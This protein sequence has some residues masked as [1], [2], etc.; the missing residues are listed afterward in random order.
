MV[1]EYKDL[2]E[3]VLSVDKGIRFAGVADYHGNVLAARYR[4]DIEK[5]P[6]L[7]GDE[8]NISV[9]QSLVRMILR[10]SQEVR[11][12]KPLYSITVYE[13]VKRVTI[14]IERGNEDYILMVSLDLAARPGPLITKKIIPLVNSLWP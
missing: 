8:F 14:P 2:C 4:D 7:S 11:L 13:K 12:G 3:Q 9:F 5:A 1:V 6:L 10:K